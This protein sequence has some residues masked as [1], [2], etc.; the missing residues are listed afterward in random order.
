MAREGWP[1]LDWPSLDWPFLDW[2]SLGW[3]LAI[4]GLVVGFAWIG[5]WVCLDLLVVGFAWIYWAKL[6]GYRG[7][8]LGLLGL[9]VLREC[10][11]RYSSH[12]L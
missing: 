1:S 11:M 5:R 7:W 4:L 9:A 10:D 2:P 8:S 3:P 6:V 12:S